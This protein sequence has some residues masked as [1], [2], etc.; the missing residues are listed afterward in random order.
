MKFYTL[1]KTVV[2]L[3]FSYQLETWSLTFPKGCLIDNLDKIC[4]TLSQVS[5]DDSVVFSTGET[6][7]GCFLL[8]KHPNSIRLINDFKYFSAQLSLILRQR[9]S[10]DQQVTY[11]LAHPEKI[12]PK[13]FSRNKDFQY[14]YS[15]YM[16]FKKLIDDAYPK[17]TP[18]KTN[19]SQN[20]VLKTVKEQ[21]KNF[22]HLAK[23]E[24]DSF[25]RTTHLKLDSQPTEQNCYPDPN[26]F[27]ST[28]MENSPILL[29]TSIAQYPMAS[30]KTVLTHEIAHTF[31]PCLYH[32]Q[33]KPA[34]PYPFQKA[35]KCL[36]EDLNFTAGKNICEQNHLR[37]AFCD[38]VS[39]T[40]LAE[41]LEK[42]TSKV[43]NIKKSSLETS[44]T[45]D[46]KNKNLILPEGYEH[47]FY[48]ID[49]YCAHRDLEESKS[50]PSSERRLLDLYLRNPK[51]AKFYGCKA[52][53]PYCDL[54]NG[55]S[56]VERDTSTSP[57]TRSKE[58]K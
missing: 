42:N 12:D 15:S 51:V 57:S 13:H 3:L 1:L 33:K 30:I 49:R 39:V 6:L 40:A 45:A 24:S 14:F 56:A 11:L 44:I 21:A 38:L 43:T 58:N 53:K 47:L 54:F 7:P 4:S 41:D 27:L 19:P 10:S 25:F 37:E 8:T 36:Q 18:T 9:H 5:P 35:I 26:A 55:L 46:K 2:F 31:D 17:K 52:T 32:T 50:H 16:T 34:S 29:T 23:E 20:E 28:D 22:L 48:T